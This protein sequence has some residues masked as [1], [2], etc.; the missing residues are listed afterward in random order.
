[1]SELKDLRDE[2]QQLKVVV[3]E[4]TLENRVLK[5]SLTASGEEAAT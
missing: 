4:I 2:N 1:M 5:E 3:A